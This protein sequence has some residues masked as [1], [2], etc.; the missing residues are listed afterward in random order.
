MKILTY[1]LAGLLFGATATAQIPDY[2]QFKTDDEENNI[3]I[4]K[5][6]SPS[7]VN[8][9][10][11]RLLRSFYSFNPQEVPQ[12]SGTGFVWDKEGYIVTNYHVIQQ[13]DRVTVTLQDGTSYAASAV[14]VDPDKDLAVLKIDATDTELVA[15]QPGDS[16]L[17]EVG[18]KVIAIGNPF[19]F[20]TTMTVGIVS[21]LG[22]EIDSVSRR[23]IRDVIQTDAA[24]NPGNS[25]GP[26]LNS[27]GQLVGVNTAIYSPTGSSSGI[28]FAIPV[29]T[30]KRIV[31]E[32]I[33]Y[34]RVQTPVMGIRQIPQADYYRGQ[35]GIEGVIVLDVFPGTDPER[36]GMRGLTRDLRGR[37]QLGDV[38]IEIDGQT[39][40]NE[41]DFADV[42][43]QRSAGDTVKVKTLRDGLIKEYEVELLSPRNR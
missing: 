8:I 7:V 6:V 37:I 38:I 5:A 1:M 16:L 33:A 28:G 29:N 19:G 2:S 34:G 27:L 23:K 30:V 3:E 14:G 42:L 11:S 26:L 17:L 22:R 35:W 10:N 21:A 9:T 43:E 13:A 41:D 4:F 31:P 20:D 25:G 40:R 32:L 18:R 24:I 12:G 36:F 15:V 39:V